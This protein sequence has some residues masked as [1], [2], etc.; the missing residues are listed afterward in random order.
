MDD[1]CNPWFCAQDACIALDIVWSGSGVTLRSMPEHCYTTI[2]YMG[3]GGVREMIFLSEAGLYRLIF[4]S[5][6]PEAVRFSDWVCEE[7]LPSIRKS[8]GFGTVPPKD[9]LA[10]SRQ[11]FILCEKLA[12]TKDAMLHQYLV[13][14]I[15]ALSNLLGQKMPDLTLLG[16]DY[17]QLEMEG[18]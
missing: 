11:I 18:V 2:R 16:K 5:N 10:Y 4:R 13:G 7:V 14:E 15:R 8:G 6:K 17:K 3:E 12:T 9:R 1:Q